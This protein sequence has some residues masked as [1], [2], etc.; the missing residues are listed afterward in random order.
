MTF[1]ALGRGVS[2]KRWR[3]EKG[4]EPGDC[5]EDED[6]AAIDHVPLVPG[7]VV[8]DVGQPGGLAQA[9]RL[10]QALGPEAAATHVACQ[11]EDDAENEDALDRPRHKAQGE[12]MGVVL[13]PGLDVEGEQAGEESHN[14][15]PALAEV[16]GSREDQDLKRGVDGIDAVVEQ[17]TERA[18]LTSAAGLGAVNGVEGLVQEQTDCPA[19]V[20]PGRAINI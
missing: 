17:L 6:D 16:H 18:T 12:G 7:E 8:H 2:E 14:R 15:L 3:T 10:Q 9:N 11:S 19:V 4:H 20:D 13:V 1:W 5:V